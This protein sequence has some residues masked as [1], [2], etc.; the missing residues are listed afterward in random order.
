MDDQVNTEVIERDT[1]IEDWS[2]ADL[3]KANEVISG[4]VE[5]DATTAQPD[6]EALPTAT[7]AA[8]KQVPKEVDRVAELTKQ[9]EGLQK[10][11]ARRETEYGEMKKFLES[12]RKEE[13]AAKSPE[14][15]EIDY[16]DPADVKAKI[17]ELARRERESADAERLQQQTTLDNRKI[18]IVGKFPEFEQYI[19]EI[20]SLVTR[21]LGEDAPGVVEA[22]NELKANPYKE[23]PLALMFAAEAVKASRRINELERQVA[24]VRDSKE[25]LLKKIERA[26]QIKPMVMGNQGGT[27]KQGLSGL[28]SKAV[29]QMSDDELNRQIKQLMRG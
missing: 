15:F 20:G 19:P 28:G 2:D 8:E 25:G 5:P 12:R 23:D 6:G 13:E 24:S 26:T 16:A 9:I 17:Q 27:A 10:L 18:L 1:P 14:E 29:E 3:S 11:T 21:L 7:Q 4:E 22:I